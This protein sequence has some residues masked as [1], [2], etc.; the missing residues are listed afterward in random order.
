MNRKWQIVAWTVFAL[1]GMTTQAQAQVRKDVIEWQK[2]PQVASQMAIQ[3]ERPLLVFVSAEWCGY[4]QK[5]KREVWTDTEVIKQVRQQ[6]VPLYLDADKYPG[7]VTELGVEAFPTTLIVNSNGK[8]TQEL[9]GFVP[10][11]QVLP[12]LKKDAELPPK[13]AAVVRNVRGGFKA[14]Q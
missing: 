8:I 7:L 11:N 6:F 9:T 2:D 10:A 4:C 14:W 1:A 13:P 3:Q 5:M 12:F